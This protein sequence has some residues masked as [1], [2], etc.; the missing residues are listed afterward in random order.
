MQNNPRLVESP[1]P[2][3]RAG[4]SSKTDRDESIM[5]TLIINWRPEHRWPVLIAANRDEM[6]DRPWKPPARHWPD[7]ADVVAGLDEEAGGSWLG[8]NDHGVVAGILN[9]T[10]S[11]GPAAGK[12]SR[13]ELVLEALDHAD[14]VDAAAALGDLDGNAYRTFNMIIA[15]NRDAL[16]VRHTGA[17]KAAI[18][19]SPVPEGISMITA[20]ELNDPTAPRIAHHLGALRAAVAPDPGAGDWTSWR[21]ILADRTEHHQG[22][23][24]SA[25]NITTGHGF[26]TVSSS[27]IALP[28][29]LDVKPVWLFRAGAPDVGDFT[30]VAI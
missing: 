2:C 28:D 19:V 17:I 13:G 8:M 18:E 4:P 27:L 15:D 5:C 26:G 30:P 16:W 10:G 6:L 11:L 12:R 9:R 29:T 22:D 23:P 3:Y 24:A 21:Q 20:Q 1:A 7:R 14:A 25:M